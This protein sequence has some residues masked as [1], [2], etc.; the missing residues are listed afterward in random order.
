MNKTLDREMGEM[1]AQVADIHK[2]V[3]GNGQPGL[4]QNFEIMKSR[5]DKYEGGLQL[6]TWFISIFGVSLFG[7]I[8]A[9]VRLYM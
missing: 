6:M 2:V 1:K 4:V 5:L 9:I 7:S 3:M 8:I